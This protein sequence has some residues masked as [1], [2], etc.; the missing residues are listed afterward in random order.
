M[1]KIADK[2]KEY[3]FEKHKGYCTKK[4]TDAIIKYGVTAEHRLTYKNVIEGNEYFWASQ[5]K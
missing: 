4:H 1:I 5:G 2:Y 3:E